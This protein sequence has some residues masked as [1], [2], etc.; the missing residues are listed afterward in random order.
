MVSLSWT[1][2]PVVTKND[3][4]VQDG[5]EEW[6]TT[7]SFRTYNKQEHT[8][9]LP[10]KIIELP[11]I[12]PLHVCICYSPDHYSFTLN[13]RMHEK[14]KYK[15]MDV[16]TE[17]ELLQCHTADRSTQP[18]NFW[19]LN[20]RSNMTIFNLTSQTGSK[21]LHERRKTPLCSPALTSCGKH[22]GMATLPARLSLWSPPDTRR[23]S[24]VWVTDRT[25]GERTVI[26]LNYQVSTA[27]SCWFTD[28]YR[29]RCRYKRKSH[30]TPWRFNFFGSPFKTTCWSNKNNV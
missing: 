27:L 30:L 28:K 14:E 20:F 6:G 8:A 10:Y 19:S 18:S 4:H 29:D 5:C 1:D 15:L 12:C 11:A 9:L 2:M 23:T 16:K 13:R 24:A 3:P 7:I 25:V 26:W 21:W 22:V 17:Q